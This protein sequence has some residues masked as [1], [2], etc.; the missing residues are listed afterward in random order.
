MKSLLITYQLYNSE[1][2]YQL[3]FN[4]LKSYTKRI[5][6]MDRVWIIKTSK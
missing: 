1:N 5:E 2:D 4:K 3:I 6:I